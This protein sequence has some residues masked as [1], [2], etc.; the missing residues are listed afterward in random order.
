MGWGHQ[1]GVQHPLVVIQEEAI[2]Q[3]REMAGGANRRVRHRKPATNGISMGVAS[4][5]SAT[6][7]MFVSTV[8][9]LTE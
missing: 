2:G 5:Q 4:G 1:V 8:G 6:T 3:S 9:T 7:P